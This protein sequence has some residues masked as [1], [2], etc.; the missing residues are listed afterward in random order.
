MRLYRLVE[1]DLRR[2]WLTLEV[3]ER[4]GRRQRQP[5]PPRDGR[6]QVQVRDDQLVTAWPPRRRIS[7]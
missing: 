3:L 2:P 7:R 5:D 6:D 1:S 4:D